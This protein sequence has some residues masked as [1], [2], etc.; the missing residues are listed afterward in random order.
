MLLLD[1]II[2][3]LNLATLL[4]W[5]VKR[6]SD[7][8]GQDV[9]E[10]SREDI[11]CWGLEDPDCGILPGCYSVIIPVSEQAKLVEI[12]RKNADNFNV[13]RYTSDCLWQL[14]GL[15]DDYDLVGMEHDAELLREAM[16]KSYGALR[17]L[18]YAPE[19]LRASDAMARKAVLENA[20]N[21]FGIH[22]ERDK[23]DWWCFCFSAEN[24]GHCPLAYYDLDGGLEQIDKILEELEYILTHFSYTF[25]HLI[26]NRLGYVYEFTSI[27]RCA[28]HIKEE[29]EKLA[30]AFERWNPAAGSID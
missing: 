8:C 28:H 22:L 3:L 17:Q 6:C 9:L 29:L 11:T 26:E 23:D 15:P 20:V 4:G 7:N 18:K 2:I 1:N 12:I 13:N 14:Y 25:Q 21:K 16:E 10:L 24:L 5:C 30:N 19:F 27:L